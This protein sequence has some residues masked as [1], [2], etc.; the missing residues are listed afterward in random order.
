MLQLSFLDYCC[1][2]HF[3]AV[4][5]YCYF[6]S[7]HMGINL[8]QS[9]SAIGMFNC[10]KIKRTC[11][12][13]LLPYLCVMSVHLL[14]WCFIL[15]NKLCSSDIQLNPGPNKIP[16]LRVCHINIRSLNLN[17]IRALK[18]IL[19][20]YDIVTISETHLDPQIEYE[21]LNLEGFHSIIR[22]DRC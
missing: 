11:C 6:Y 17:K 8:A 13:L 16:F 15:S 18:T 20:D 9:R 1:L 7:T 21:F 5:L 22:K 14:I 19:Q 3:T 12:I 2:L 4:Y 10:Y